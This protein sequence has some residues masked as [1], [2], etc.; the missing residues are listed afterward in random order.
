MVAPYMRDYLVVMDYFWPMRQPD[1]MDEIQTFAKTKMLLTEGVT[2][3]L[4]HPFPA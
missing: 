1:I 4:S 2:N 3:Q